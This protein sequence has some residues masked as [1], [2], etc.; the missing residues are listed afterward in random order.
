MRSS[1]RVRVLLAALVLVTGGCGSDEQPLSSGEGE[2]ADPAELPGSAATD[3]A[4]W[5]T[6]LGP[7]RW[8]GVRTSPDGRTLVVTF[9]GGAPYVEDQPCT[10]DYRAVVTESRSTVEVE[11]QARQPPQ[12]DEL[13]CTAAGSFRQ[14]EAELAEPLGDRAVLEQRS[15]RVQNVYDGQLLAEPTWLPD[16]WA[17]QRESAGFPEPEAATSWERTWGPP[18]PPPS[19]D[20]TCTPSDSPVTLTQGPAAAVDAHSAEGRAVS[21]HDVNGHEA[22]LY[23]AEPSAAG[24]VWLTWVVEPQSFLLMS[25]PSCFDEGTPTVELLLRFAEGLAVPGD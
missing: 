11:L 8:D 18:A 1:L 25:G 20:G 14:V 19:E 16:G 4:G 17:L 3:D 9:V 21:T 2:T 7:G 15:E 6:E 13:F 5:S 10:V 12:P 24:A 22:T 23:E